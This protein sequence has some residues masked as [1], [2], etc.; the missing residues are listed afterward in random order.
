MTTEEQGK[1]A[2]GPG[3]SIQRTGAVCAEALSYNRRRSGRGF[4]AALRMAILRRVA[5][6]E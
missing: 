1:K 3:A 4:F 6:S 5:S 2:S